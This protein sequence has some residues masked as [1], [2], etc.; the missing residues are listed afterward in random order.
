MD[1]TVIIEGLPG[2]NGRYSNRPL[3]HLVFHEETEAGLIT[4][5]IYT[6]TLTLI[7]SPFTEAW[8]A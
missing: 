6:D 4:L 7:E 3:L 2:Q 1:Q 8:I 5:E